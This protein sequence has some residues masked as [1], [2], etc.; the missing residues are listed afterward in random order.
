M[1]IKLPTHRAYL[2]RQILRALLRFGRSQFVSAP[3][4]A[5]GCIGDRSAASVGTVCGSMRQ[6]IEGRKGP[7]GGYRIRLELRDQ[8]AASIAEAG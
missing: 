7:N 8:I 5:A 4:I 1:T 3:R 2:Q 6:W